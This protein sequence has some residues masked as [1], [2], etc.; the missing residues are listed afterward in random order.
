MTRLLWKLILIP[1]AVLLGDYLI[2]S[3]FYPSYLQPILTGLALA[4][5]QHAMEKVWLRTGTLW[6]MTVLDILVAAA[7]LWLSAAAFPGARVPLDGALLVALLL[8]IVEYVY[9][10]WLLKNPI[11]ARN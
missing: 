9:H 1:A 5:A 2:G 7:V 11:Y 10:R 4:V 3:V 8:G 6:L